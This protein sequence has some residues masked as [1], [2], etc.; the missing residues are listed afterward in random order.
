MDYVIGNFTFRRI[1]VAPNS[2]AT[3][4]LGV[5]RYALL[6]SIA[7]ICAAILTNVVKKGQ[8]DANS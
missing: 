5:F 4:P 7:S 2:V 3:S 1:W 8:G 6:F